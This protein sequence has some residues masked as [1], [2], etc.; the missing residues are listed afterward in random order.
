MYPAYFVIAIFSLLSRMARGRLKTRA[1]SRSA[2]SSRYVEYTYSMSNG[3][4]LRMITAAKSFS[5]RV[6]GDAGAIPMVVSGGKGQ[7]LHRPAGHIPVPEDIALT[8]GKD[9]MSTAVERAHHRDAR[10]LVG[11]ERRQGIEDEGEVHGNRWCRAASIVTHRRAEGLGRT[12]WCT[13]ARNFA[14]LRIATLRGNAAQPGGLSVRGA[15]GTPGCRRRRRWPPRSRSAD[16]GSRRR[17]RSESARRRH[18]AGPRIR[19][20]RPAT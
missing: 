4:S 9:A 5:G 14:D 2:H 15:P 20:G 3:G 18:R 6:S 13:R 10:V 8:Q 1:P 11:L 12:V 17:R 19:P 16:S 7:R